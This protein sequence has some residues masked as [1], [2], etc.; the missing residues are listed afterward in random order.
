[1]V[2]HEWKT[3]EKS[4]IVDFNGI[5]YY[6]YPDSKSHSKRCYYTCS[7]GNKK[8][9]YST[10]HRDIWQYEHNAE[11][12]EGYDIHHKDG[13]YLNN[14]IENLELITRRDHAKEHWRM[15]PEEK[16][17]QALESIKKA[18][19]RNTELYKDINYR[20][21]MSERA[22]KLASE[23]SFSCTCIE[24]KRQF[25]SHVENTKYCSKACKMSGANRLATERRKTYYE[26]RQ[27]I[28]CGKQFMCNRYNKITQTCSP[29]CKNI[30]RGW[31]IHS[32]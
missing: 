12:P 30:K 20:K 16:R 22:K 13:N 15:Q 6:R 2:K 5:R 9:G 1:M 27:C 25:V 32:L 29:H 26:K 10:L 24:C 31:T 23:R 28:V 11:I 4:E 17:K 18:Q 21:A 19:E 7:N 8:K 14:N 3:R